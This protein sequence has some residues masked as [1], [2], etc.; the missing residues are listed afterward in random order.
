MMIVKKKPIKGPNKVVCDVL[1]ESAKPLGA[2]EILERV[3]VLGI[4]GPPTVYRALNKLVKLGMAHRVASTR[5]YVMCRH[6][7][8]HTSEAV[9]MVVC[10]FCD[11]VAEVP[12][13]VIH[14]ELESIRTANGFKIRDEIIEI[15]GICR[16]CGG[17]K[18]KG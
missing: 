7:S 3:K 2:Y 18:G 17:S 8:E 12:S 13:K 6:G 9:V 11:D 15:S 1:S 4:N 14:G 5:S 16:N 10:N